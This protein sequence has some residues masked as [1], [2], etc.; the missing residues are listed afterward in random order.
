VW[1]YVDDHGS[2]A[3]EPLTG[4]HLWFV[5][6]EDGQTI[7]AECSSN[8]N[9]HDRFKLSDEQEGSLEA[10]GW[11]PPDVFWT[12]N[13]NASISSEGDLD[14]LCALVDETLI[15]VFGLTNRSRIVI[16]FQQSFVEHSS[17]AA[18]LPGA[19]A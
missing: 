13:W 4:R 2:R 1:L 12:P 16:G 9:L 11:R 17:S 15:D 7:V 10:L 18:P 6:L 5:V 8:R 19:P 3:G 14:A